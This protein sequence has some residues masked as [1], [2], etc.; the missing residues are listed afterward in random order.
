MA[1]RRRFRGVWLGRAAVRHVHALQKQLARRA[2][3]RARIGHR[4]APR[5]RAGGHARPRERIPRT[6]S[7]AEEALRARGVEYVQARAAAT[8]RSRARTARR[9]PHRRISRRIAATSARYV[10]DLAETMRRVA[11]V[12]AS[13][14]AKSRGSSGSGWIWIPPAS[15]PALAPARDLAKI[16]AI[17]VRISRWVTMHG[18]ALNVS[19]AP[20]L[21]RMIVP[22]GIREHEVTSIFELSRTRPGIHAE[23]AAALELLAAVMDADILRFDDISAAPLEPW[24][25]ELRAENALDQTLPSF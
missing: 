22:C 3:A 25:D 8:S 24:L 12:T 6:S 11:R 17:G 20:D 21:F 10:R 14:A 19:T 15:G 5:A 2:A 23:A 4:A 16:G 13:R 9:L 18:F 1:E 7:S